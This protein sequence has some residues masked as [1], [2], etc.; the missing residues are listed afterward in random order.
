MTLIEEFNI[1]KDAVM[2]KL[3]ELND[4]NK[5]RAVHDTLEDMIEVYTDYLDS[6][7]DNWN[8]C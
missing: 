6:E 8:G 1:I 3:P 5:A 2:Q 7:A 4:D